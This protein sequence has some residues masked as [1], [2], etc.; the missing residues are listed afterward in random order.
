MSLTSDDLANIRQLVEAVVAANNKVLVDEVR[1]RFTE[2]DEKLDEIMNAVGTDL[3]Q[4]TAM[5]E[6]HAQRIGQ[7]ENAK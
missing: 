2:Q 7:L 5:L 6:D 4:H 3:A 1:Q